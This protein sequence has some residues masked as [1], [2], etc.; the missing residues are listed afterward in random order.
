LT[1]LGTAA[2]AAGCSL[3]GIDSDWMFHDSGY[4]LDVAP[5][6]DEFAFRVHVNQLKQLGGDVK[7]AEFRLFV[8]ERLK[9]HD[10]CPGGWEEQLCAEGQSC[11]QRTRTS[12][13]VL[14]RCLP[15]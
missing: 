11:V 5:Y 9:F 14:G 12:V 4:S 8:S 6:G 10:V 2:L 13:T 3:M 15:R 1:A 7:S